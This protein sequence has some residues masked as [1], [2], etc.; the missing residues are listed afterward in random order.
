MLVLDRALP[1]PDPKPNDVVDEL[2]IVGEVEN[3]G[4]VEYG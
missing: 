4:I 1:K 3:V 2:G